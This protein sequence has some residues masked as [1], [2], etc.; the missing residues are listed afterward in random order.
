M[1]KYQLP[2]PHLSPSQIELY[3][4]CPKQYEW[5]YIHCITGKPALPLVE[6]SSHHVALEQANKHEIKT[7]RK[8]SAAKL[9]EYF[10][11]HFAEYSGGIGDWCG[12]TPDSVI[13]R[14]RRLLR[15]YSVSIAPRIKP[16][17]AEFKY[18]I[19]NKGLD[20]LCIVDL[21]ASITKL[22]DRFAALDYKVVKKAKSMSEL[23]ESLQLLAYSLV[24]AENV[25]VNKDPKVGYVSFEKVSLRTVLTTCR[26]FQKRQDKFWRVAHKVAAEITKGNFPRC[27]RG[28]WFCDERWCGYWE[29]CR[30]AQ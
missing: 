17:L 30:N 27:D 2:K 5:R 1:P 7:G 3:L 28:M 18:T 8:L 23:R 19:R 26:V 21:I 11:D 25:P 4:R 6:G 9:T 29:D 14:G 12:E 16:Q 24:M 10:A 22:P 20:V 13:R 15:S